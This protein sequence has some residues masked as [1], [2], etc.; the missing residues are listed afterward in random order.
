[1]LP[2]SVCFG[3]E[4]PDGSP[5]IKYRA[6]LNSTD[7]SGASVSGLRFGRPA[8]KMRG[9]FSM[10]ERYIKWYTPWLRAAARFM[11]EALSLSFRAKFRRAKRSRGISNSLN[12]SDAA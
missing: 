6:S 7:P 3:I 5:K 11:I 2:V 9:L 4:K 10:N 1:M 12:L 8:T